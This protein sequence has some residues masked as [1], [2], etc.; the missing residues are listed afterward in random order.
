MVD[1]ETKQE[2]GSNGHDSD[3]I[4]NYL[5]ELLLLINY[6]IYQYMFTAYRKN[7]MYITIYIINNFTLISI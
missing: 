7:Y 2:L 1:I 4:A 3:F 5:C 6:H